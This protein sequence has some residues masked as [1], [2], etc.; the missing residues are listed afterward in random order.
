VEKEA[1]IETGAV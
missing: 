1:Y